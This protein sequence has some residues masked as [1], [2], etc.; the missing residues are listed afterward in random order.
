M[1]QSLDLRLGQHLTITPQLQQAIRL[2]QL[3]SIELQQEIQ[4]AL[5]SNPLLEEKEEESPDG[6]RAEGEEPETVAEGEPA[7]EMEAV[8]EAADATDTSPEFDAEIKPTDDM[9]RGALDE[10]AGDSE[11]DENFD[12][13]MTSSTRSNDEDLPDIDARNSLPLTLRDHLSWQMQMTPFSETDRRIAEALIDA[14]ND[15]GYLTVPL[16]DI[17]QALGGGPEMGPEEVE[18]VL[19]QIQNF[20]PAGVGARNLSECLTLQLKTLPVDTPH[21]K[22]ALA[23]VAPENLPLL[24]SRD[25]NALRRNLKLPAEQLQETILLVQRLNPRPGSTVQSSQAAYIVPDI[26]VKKIKGVWRAELNPDI[27]P[28]L[29]INRQYERMIHRGDSSTSNRYLQDQLQQARWFIKSLTSRNDTLLKVARTIVD[30]QRAFFDHGPE[31]MKPLVLHDIAEAVNMHESTISRVTTNKYMLTP[32]GIF[33]LKYF[34]SSHVATADGGACS[35]TAIRSMI[36]KLVEAEPSTKPISDSTIADILAKQ[37][38]NVARRTIA[39]YR[40]SMNIPP[41]SQRKSLVTSS[42]KKPCKSP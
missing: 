34:F 6:Q 33:E 26:I 31:A 11:W 2:L 10:P 42:E 27:A 32:R 12:V 38:I 19:H 23:L 4:E 20:D 13:P 9:E 18:A 5:E 37:G 35:A 17:Q 15:D 30:R 36:K 1:K 22:D 21:L 25:Y 24:G 40:E 28:R 39:K 14:I 3:S 29:R 8:G 41:S 16:T 7:G